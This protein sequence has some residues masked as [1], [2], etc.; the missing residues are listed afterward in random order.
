[1]VPMEIGAERAELALD[2]AARPPFIPVWKIPSCCPIL[3]LSPDPK[4]RPSNW[5]VICNEVSS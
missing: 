1:M 2:L 3:M 4:L 5:D